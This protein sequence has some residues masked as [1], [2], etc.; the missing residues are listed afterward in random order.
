ME[1]PIYQ[2]PNFQEPE[3]AMRH[4]LYDMLLLLGAPLHIAELMEVA[5]DRP[6][7]RA[8]IDIMR[9]YNCELL[10]AAKHRLAYIH[11]LKVQVSPPGSE[12]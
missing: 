9:A 7:N 5:K 10:N 8:E 2:D 11:T 3:F 4:C 12:G 1:S 6:L